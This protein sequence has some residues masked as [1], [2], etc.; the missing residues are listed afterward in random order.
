MEHA[1]EWFTNDQRRLGFFVALILIAPLALM[2][3]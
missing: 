2:L 1:L 3:M